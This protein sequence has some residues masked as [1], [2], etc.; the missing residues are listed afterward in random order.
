M[1]KI[2][3]Q[4]KKF[5]KYIQAFLGLGS[6]PTLVTLPTHIFSKKA[7]R[8]L[9]VR[10][11]GLGLWNDY[12]LIIILN[13]YGEAEEDEE[14]LEELC[15]FLFFDLDLDFESDL[16]L[17]LSLILLLLSLLLLLLELSFSS[18]STSL[19]VS[20]K[21]FIKLNSSLNFT[22]KGTC[23]KRDYSTKVFFQ[24]YHSPSPS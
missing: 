19:V 14:E 5:V 3:L 23:N 18:G 2:K 6:V 13:P 17:L 9:E 24:I 4:Y 11:V 21:F 8:F 16:L 20:D 15:L 1:T 12:I 10:K 22:Q 7:F